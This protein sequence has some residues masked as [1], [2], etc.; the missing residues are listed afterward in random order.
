MPK[1]KTPIEKPGKQFERFAETVRDHGI[2]EADEPIEKAFKAVKKK[3]VQSP[4]KA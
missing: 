2:D 3:V 1:R 4:K